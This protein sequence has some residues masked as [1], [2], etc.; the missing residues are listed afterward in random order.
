MFGVC[1]LRVEVQPEHLLI[2]IT[3]CHSPDAG[4]Q[5]VFTSRPRRVASAE[6]ALASAG[7]FLASFVRW[8]E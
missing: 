6:E 2:T 1:T 3:T 4:A 5:R 7:E 8:A